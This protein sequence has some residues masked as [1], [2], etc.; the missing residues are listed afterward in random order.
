MWMNLQNCLIILLN[1][2]D[3]VGNV[4]NLWNVVKFY[5]EYIKKAPFHHSFFLWTICKTC[6]SLVSA[7]PG[8]LFCL[9]SIF[10]VFV[11]FPLVG[12][13]RTHSHLAEEWEGGEGERPERDSNVENHLHGHQSSVIIRFCSR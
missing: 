4:K 7:I 1:V 3:S 6:V 2:T 5:K 12:S 9:C 8:N 10:F 11:L 13:T